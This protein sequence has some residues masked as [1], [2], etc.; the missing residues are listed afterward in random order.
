MPESHQVTDLVHR[1]FE[2]V[3]AVI[4]VPCFGSIHHGGGN[5]IGRTAGDTDNTT[6]PCR[7]QRIDRSQ[8]TSGDAKHGNALIEQVIEHNFVGFDELHAGIVTE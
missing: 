4:V 5:A 3:F 7:H 1:G 8:V 2:P 6:R